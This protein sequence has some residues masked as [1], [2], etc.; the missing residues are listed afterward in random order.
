MRSPLASAIVFG[1]LHAMK[2]FG[3]VVVAAA[4]LGACSALPKLVSTNIATG[5]SS[6][7]STSSSSGAVVDQDD[8]RSGIETTS[9]LGAEPAGFR[10]T[11][12]RWDS[13][14]RG[15]DLRIGDR[16]IAVN[17]ERY[18][19][20]P[21]LEDV[22]RMLP[23]VIDGYAESQHW[24]ERGT[25]DGTE[26]ELTV[27]RRAASGT[28]VEIHKIRGKVL[29]DRIYSE[30]TKRRMGPG[31]PFALEQDG[32]GSA[33]S[34]WYEA[35]VREWEKVL[36]RGWTQQ[37]VQTRAALDK[38]LD[39]R[40]RIDFLLKK[41]PGP[42]AKAADADWT[43]VRDSLMGR[44]YEIDER[45]L[46]Y[47]RLGEQR[48]GEIASAATSLGE[49]S[50]EDQEYL[51]RLIQERTNALAQALDEAA[52]IPERFRKDFDRSRHGDEIK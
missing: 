16:V 6:S 46:A 1:S 17:G 28:G 22:Q 20:P 23:K 13:G 8:V 45:D 10:V 35:Q 21:K 9:M 36:D 3:C 34:G 27:Q 14:F 18:V 19:K 4:G 44:R 48:A 40:P 42:F 37:Q 50:S 31:G 29:A 52:R 30:G 25:R 11:W 47:R 41:F 49:L 12:I 39:E 7:S 26:I 32:F 43:R 24:K 51:R 33:W 38:H 5:T 2:V 15:T